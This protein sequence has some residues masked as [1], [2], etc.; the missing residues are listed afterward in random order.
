M[1]LNGA[2]GAIYLRSLLGGG[3]GSPDGNALDLYCGLDY[4]SSL[5]IPDRQPFKG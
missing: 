1:L 5:L 3:G 4:Y 2:L